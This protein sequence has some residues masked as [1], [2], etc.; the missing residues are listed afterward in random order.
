MQVL[1]NQGMLK[2]SKKGLGF[3]CG[4]EP[5]PGIFA[6]HG[7]SVVATDLSR[8]AAIEQ[9]WVDTLQHANDLEDL[10]KAC[11]KI[12]DKNLFF[13]RVSFRNVDMNNV[14]DEFKGFDFVWSAC[15]F[16]HLGSLRHGMEFVKNS[17]KCL[18]PGGV[19]IHTTEFNLSSNKGTI[20]NP[21][22]SVYRDKDSA[23]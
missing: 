7:C 22:C 1:S 6:R 23:N 11:N 4:A 12:L 15:A 20:E 17:I 21:G 18:K 14:P 19:A 2:T 16:E 5:M 9:G 10:Y 3:G 8:E 13:D